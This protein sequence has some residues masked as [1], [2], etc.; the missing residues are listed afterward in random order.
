MGKPTDVI[1]YDIFGKWDSDG[2][3]VSMDEIRKQLEVWEKRYPDYNLYLE[4]YLQYDYEGAS[5][6]TGI[7]LAGEPKQ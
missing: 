1:E 7:K 3:R 4:R 5:E 6:L 2:D